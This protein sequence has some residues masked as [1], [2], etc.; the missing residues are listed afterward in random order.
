MW[1]VQGNW[2]GLAAALLVASGCAKIPKAQLNAYVST[3]GEAEQAGRTVLSDWRSARAEL[4]RRES[5]IK[6]DGAPATP[7]PLERPMP[8]A[9]QA[10]L[11]AED[12]R[13]LAWGAIAEY[14][15]VLA[16]LNAGESVGEVKQT[17]GRLFD[18]A[19]RLAGG[20]FPGGGAAAELL[21][22]FAGRIEEARLAK[23]FKTAVQA[24]AP[25]LKKIISDVLLE[26]IRDHYRLRAVLASEDYAAVE[27]DEALDDEGK[28]L[29]RIRIQ[30][31]TKAFAGTLDAYEALLRK[32]YATLTAM[33][34]SMNQ[35]IDFAEEANRLLDIATSLKQQ[36]EAYQNARR[37]SR[38]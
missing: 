16:R 34:H 25:V 8:P 28:A 9:G 5:V 1:R 18:L 24:G 4:E 10:L 21:K 38:G 32:T 6:S 26:D 31:E 36:F 29:K 13:E 27:L 17:T 20:A 2:L 30:D 33:E 35:P 15:T 37:E 22:E 11:S 12:T 14:T 19:T 23:E 7:F 3:V